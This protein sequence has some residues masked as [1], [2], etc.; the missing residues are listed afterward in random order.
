MYVNKNIGKDVR[1]LINEPSVQKYEAN[2]IHP[3]QVTTPYKRELIGFHAEHIQETITKFKN[4]KI[5]LKI[6]DL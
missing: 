2:V 6:F 3:I 4:N 5:I 1:E